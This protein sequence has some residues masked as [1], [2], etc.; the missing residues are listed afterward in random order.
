MN[1]QQQ[2][3]FGKVLFFVLAATGAAQACKDDAPD[4]DAPTVTGGSGGSSGSSNQGG[5]NNR[6]GS[7]GTDN[8]GGENSGGTTN[9]GGTSGSSA[10]GGT[11]SQGGTSPRG[12][13]SGTSNDGGVGNEGGAGP[14]GCVRNPTEPE[15]FLNRCTDARCAPFDNEARIPGFNGTLPE[16]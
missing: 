16:L 8:P 5:T 1:K 4:A 14:D 13:S 7:S 2:H 15:D 12:G 6:G 10:R 3:R 11:T 9:A